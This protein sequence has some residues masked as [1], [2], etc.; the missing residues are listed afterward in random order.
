MDQLWVC[1]LGREDLT[2][3]WVKAGDGPPDDGHQ[4]YLVLSEPAVAGS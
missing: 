4:W 3:V 1:P 2:W